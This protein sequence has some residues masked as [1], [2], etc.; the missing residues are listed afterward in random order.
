MLESFATEASS[1]RACKITLQLVITLQFKLTSGWCLD[2]L[3][4]TK[5]S[6]Q[7]TV[8]NNQNL[9]WRVA[10]RL[11]DN[12]FKLHSIYRFVKVYSPQKIQLE[13]DSNKKQTQTVCY[14]NLH[15]K[16]SE[17]SSKILFKIIMKPFCGWNS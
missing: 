8:V 10:P 2:L 3:V 16:L 11:P 15:I 1:W 4:S 7:Q 14:C 17:E 12:L 5:I 9:V 13:N 6:T